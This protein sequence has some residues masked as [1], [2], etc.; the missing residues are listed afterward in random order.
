MDQTSFGNTYAYY[1]DSTQLT[2][3]R[4]RYYASSTG[5]FLTRDIWGGDDNNPL[6]FNRWGY[7][8]E[9]PIMY[10]DPTGLLPCPWNLADPTCD[11]ND[12]TAWFLQGIYG[13]LGINTNIYIPTNSGPTNFAGAV[14]N[15]YLQD[16][17]PL[18]NTY[19]VIGDVGLSAMPGGNIGYNL[20]QAGLG[21]N[22]LGSQLNSNQR[23]GLAFWGLLGL[24]DCFSGFHFAPNEMGGGYSS[25][26]ISTGKYNSRFLSAIDSFIE[27]S[28]K[29]HPRTSFGSTWRGWFTAASQNTEIANNLIL[30]SEGDELVGVLR[31]QNGGQEFP[32][33]LRLMDIEALNSNASAALIKEAARESID[34]GLNGMY[35]FVTTNEGALFANRTGGKLLNPSNKMYYWD[36]ETVY[37]LIFH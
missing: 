24:G 20:T 4:S 27:K 17:Q 33:A 29:L 7:V 26:S 9:N 22:L 3:L 15:Q 16:V 5:R 37:N 25:P 31:I 18:A 32:N 14:T 19:Y 1:G 2:Y 8:Y 36:L 35:G 13:A 6:S 23:L 11:V 28:L 12:F 30:A 10:I 34:R 21:S